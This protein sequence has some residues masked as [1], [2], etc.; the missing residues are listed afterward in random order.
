[1]FLL[2]FRALKAYTIDMQY[3]QIKEG[4]KT[5][6]KGFGSIG[7]KSTTTPITTL[8]ETLR[9]SFYAPGNAII[10]RTIGTVFIILLP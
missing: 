3:K 1:M 8:I 9:F 10:P 7:K 5:K 4:G 6:P 2:T